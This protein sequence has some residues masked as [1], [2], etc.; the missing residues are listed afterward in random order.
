MDRRGEEGEEN[1]IG[2]GVIEG[3]VIGVGEE[4]VRGAVVGVMEE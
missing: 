4:V 2:E 1:E 3:I